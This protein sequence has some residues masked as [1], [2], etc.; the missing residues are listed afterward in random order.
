LILLLVGLSGVV[1]SLQAAKI[2]SFS[3]QGTLKGVRQI[4]V[5]FS[6]AMVPLSDPR[7]FKTPFT[8]NCQPTQKGQGRWADTKNWVYSFEADPPSG[9][10]CEFAL[11]PGLKTLKGEAIETVEPYELSTG[12]PVVVETVPNA[13]TQYWE[14]Q[15][16]EDQVFMLKFDGA[17]DPASLE[18]H[19]YFIVDG[20][21]AKVEARVLPPAE[22][23]PLLKTRARNARDY[24]LVQARQVFPP[25]ARVKLV[26][27]KGAAAKSGIRSETE[28]EFLYRARD[29]F[30]ATFSCE[31][32][33]ADADC[34]PF[35]DFVISFS[36]NVER[37]L[38]QKIRLTGP[39]GKAI[40]PLERKGSYERDFVSAVQFKGPFSEKTNYEVTVPK[41]VDE[42]GREL[43]NAQRFP[44]RVKTAGF[45]PLAKFSSRF[46]ILELGSPVLPVT[47]RGLGPSLPGRILTVGKESGDWQT[48]AETDIIPGVPV[49]TEEKFNFPKSMGAR[50]RYWIE[51]VAGQPREYSVFETKEKTQKHTFRT[52]KFELPK[53][54]GEKAFEVIGIPF[55]E[56]GLY[57][58]ELESPKLG[59][60]LLGTLSSLYVP[61]VVLVSNLSVHYKRGQESSLV[62]VTSLDKG[63][64]IEGANVEIADAEGNVLAKGKTGP[65][66]TVRTNERL[67]PL[68]GDPKSAQ[69]RL[70][71]TARKGDDLSF[72]FSEWDEGI[73]P[74][75]FNLPA[76]DS[77][78]GLVQA[79]SV[80]DR[81]LLRAGDTVH[82]KHFLRRRVG[83][84]FTRVNKDSLPVEVV[85]RHSGSEQEYR[86]KLTWNED[87][88]SETTWQIPAD[89][90][91]GHYSI[92]LNLGAGKS[93]AGDSEFYSGGFRVEEFRVPL[94]QGRT[95][96]PD[97]PLVRPA[98]VTADVYVKYLSG[99]G[100][101]GLTGKL[102][103][104]VGD[105]SYVTVPGFDDY[106]FDGEKIKE[107]VKRRG[108]YDEDRQTP[109]SEEKWKSQ[110]FTLDGSG[111][112]RVT[113]TKISKVSRP[114]TLVTELEYRDSN[115]DVQ[116]VGG[117]AP[118]WSADR[119]IG[120]RVGEWQLR[121]SD[122][123]RV[124][125]AV[126]DLKGK[127][128]AGAPVKFELYQ[129]KIYSHRKRL[130]GG[131]YGYEHTNET[132]RLGA[133]CEGTTDEKG[134]VSC[135]GK[136]P[137]VGEIYF[138]ASTRDAA[139]ETA[140]ASR[141][142][143]VYGSSESWFA[144][145]DNDRIDLIP[146]KKRYEPGEMA[147]FQIRMPFRAATVLLTTER[148]GV[149]EN[150]VKRVTGKDPWVEIPVKGNYA[151]NIFVSA[152]V[153]R[154]RVGDIQPT[155][156]V[157]LG[158]PAYKLGIAQIHVGWKAHELKVTLQA[159]KDEYRVRQK[160]KVKI[161]VV[162]ADGAPMPEGAEVALAAVDEGLLELY[163]NDSWELLRSM[164]GERPLRV[165][166][167]TAQ[168]HVIGKRHFGLKA[169]PHGGG[170]GAGSTRELFDTL[171]TWQG[172]VKLD[173][174]GEASAEIPLND[175]L[176]S[177]RIVA[178]AHAGI[179]RFGTGEISIRSTQELMLMSG[180]PLM[181]RQGDRFD[182]RFTLRNTQNEP[183]KV[184]VTFKA[185]KLDLEPAPK[186]L[187]LPAGQSQVLSWPVILDREVDSV[188][189]E[190]DAQS[191]AG[192]SDRIKVAQ[193]IVAAIP[194]R[195]YQGTIESLT[196]SL[197]IPVE[198]PAGAIA[199]KGGVEVKLLPKLA[200]GLPGL[201][202][203]WV[204]YPYSCLEQKV[205]RAIA[206][207]D[208]T[209]LEKINRELP[210]YLDRDG[211]LKYFPDNDLGSEVLTSYVMTIANEASWSIDSGALESM[212]RALTG[213]V[214]GRVSRG[215]GFAT[216]D[217]ALRKVAAMEALSRWG[218]LDKGL[219]GYL[220]S[221]FTLWPT[222]AV[223]DLYNVL[224]RNDW[225]PERERKLSEAE[226]LLRGRMILSGRSLGFSTEK[227]DRLYWLMV[228]PDL[229][230]ARLLSTVVDQPNWSADVPRIVKGFL[231]RRD[232]GAWDI[233]T[234]NVWGKLA[235]DK[236]SRAFESV[237]V[238][239]ITGVRLEDQ[240]ATQDWKK[241]PQGTPLSFAWPSK[242]ANVKFDSAGTT[243]KP[244][245]EVQT[246]AAIPL[247]KPLSAGYRIRK[248]AVAVERK[249]PAVWTEGDIIRYTLQIDAETDMSWVV[250]ND[251]IPAGSVI[252]G[253]I[254][255]RGADATSARDTTRY[256]S[257]EERSFEGYRAYYD[258]VP[259]GKW[260][261]SYS[262]RLGNAGTFALPSTRVEAM[263]NPEAFG[264]SPNRPMTVK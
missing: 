33:N 125:A 36:A 243:G 247:K 213:F 61:T 230:A 10:R 251:P 198:R 122:P 169:Q 118:L 8:V 170:G 20:L 31:R 98:Q 45:P 229:N 144:A 149:M 221:E 108:D 2:D 89:T 178:V 137:E 200:A 70:V 99:G 177:F 143:W 161:K 78:Y 264:E 72:V 204:L 215:T 222:S 186:T 190:V 141:S 62:W 103:Y 216:A 233:T 88:T 182:A 258:Y 86:Q 77:E 261:V 195:T 184:T 90:K 92:G 164:M 39:D 76:S 146:E 136:L 4:R 16:E 131:F 159:D 68:N 248:Q 117:R 188:T 151:P 253:G 42:A 166:T 206:L 145:E 132:K 239:G 109:E 127:P 22:A 263:Y 257:Y 140:Y 57:V 157:D 224:K 52:D 183:L 235:L 81:S 218:A 60:A 95:K 26:L 158:R 205:S 256:P 162:T 7:G 121:Q 126:V 107:G 133:F 220:P 124:F 80:L 237:P 29:P 123:T 180:M 43:S 142:A 246:R 208:S 260:T 25:K 134:L 262:V 116:T 84:G 67:L 156:M 196:G 23:A 40:A 236:F 203:W 139:G 6:D 160:A 193:K 187:T 63:L 49:R 226:N 51:R 150:W 82:M 96:F 197:T 73:E 53:P 87:G 79:S 155:A 104:H 240:T 30:T 128:V 3:P 135:E 165:T 91:L 214:Q 120:I 138:Q 28:Q 211:L 219:A 232:R 83:A 66:G 153:V 242:L 234:A 14:T 69:G 259:K 154:G 15:V 75:R 254:V 185:P 194:V 58:V 100:A 5:T 18:K 249:N 34:T 71:V 189:Y 231:A 1:S 173:R 223:L 41:L 250:V 59:E 24:T 64:P 202:D 207:D 47:V 130:V 210:T 129:A 171:L 21:P 32:E 191:E 48:V 112:A 245:V 227:E 65:D 54:N 192:A 179:D 55:K 94:M 38:A 152:L 168:M 244:W 148:E 35:A 241:H 172:R 238:T 46:G 119:R 115:G 74:W 110:N 56:P 114:S 27:E 101:S 44:L 113:M 93:I 217:L 11:A 255:G 106:T 105:W 176:T 147:R 19:L 111:S 252:L 17:I 167:S 209:A 181:M 102:R 201:R 97:E 85:F 212:K 163:R 174:N 225:I 50:I 9:V 13:S 175:S 228:S 12:G 199:G 37:T